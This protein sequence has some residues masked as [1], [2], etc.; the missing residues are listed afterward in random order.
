MESFSPIYHVPVLLLIVGAIGLSIFVAPFYEGIIC[1]AV[2]KVS[3]GI[4]G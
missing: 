4:L 2:G 1:P 3:S